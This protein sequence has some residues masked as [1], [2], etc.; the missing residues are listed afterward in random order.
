MGRSA[1]SERKK[2]AIKCAGK[3]LSTSSTLLKMW[4]LGSRNMMA[5]F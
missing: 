5:P 3:K 4:Q 1:F 2:N